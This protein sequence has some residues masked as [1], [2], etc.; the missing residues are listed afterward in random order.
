MAKKKKKSPA[1]GKKSKHRFSH[2]QREAPAEKPSVFE[3]RSGRLKFDILGRKTRGVKGDALKARAAGT[4]KR[5]NTL[6]KE[7]D[8][9][10]KANAFVDRRF[11]EGDAGMTCLLYTSPSPRDK[12]QSRMPSSA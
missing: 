6:L 7:H 1:T 8:A 10:G 5:R 9:S 3:A 11:G 4:A 12:R 2:A